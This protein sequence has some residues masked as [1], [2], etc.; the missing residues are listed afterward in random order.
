MMVDL[1]SLTRPSSGAAFVHL[2]EELL[3]V[4]RGACD[5]RRHALLLRR[6]GVGNVAVGAVRRA[7][8]F[9]SARCLLAETDNVAGQLDG[10]H[11]LF[12]SLEDCAQTNRTNER[13]Q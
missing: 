12:A 8:A 5:H 10:A 3:H 11:E 9:A 13:C 2:V 6:T 1:A 4:H 7:V